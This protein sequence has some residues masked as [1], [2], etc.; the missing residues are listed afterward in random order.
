MDQ[1]YKPKRSDLGQ[2]KATFRGSVQSLISLAIVL[3][4]VVVISLVIGLFRGGSLE[5]IIKSAPAITLTMLGLYGVF[6][7]LIKFHSVSV[8]SKGLEGKNIG[9]GQS[10]FIGIRSR[11]CISNQATAWT[12]LY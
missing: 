5:N 12:R 6:Y 7:L 2:F 11:A 4:V 8:Y 1:G 10:D 3:V 9:A